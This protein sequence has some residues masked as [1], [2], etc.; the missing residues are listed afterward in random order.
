MD[1]PTFRS[2][3]NH[4]RLYVDCTNETRPGREHWYYAAPE[5][6]VLGYDAE[7]GQFLGSFGSDGFV[8][9]GQPPGARFQGELRYPTRAWDAWPPAY[10][11]FP[12]AVYEIH[13]SRR[14]IRTLFRP[15]SGETV[16]WAGQWRDRRDNKTLAVV[17]TDRSVHVLTEA[18]A[19]VVALPRAY[20][21]ARYTLNFVRLEGP[22]RY[23]IWY[24]PSPF[25]EPHEVATTPSHLV[26]YDAAGHE[27]ARRTVPRHARAEPSAAA[28][29]LGLATPPTELA[30]LAG[31]LYYLRAQA[32]ATGG[33][34]TWIHQMFLEES[35]GHFLQGIARG[36]G[37]PGGLHA[38]FVA[39]SLL[40]AVAGALVCFLLARRFAFSGA[41]SIAWALIGLLFGWAGVALMFALQDWPARIPCPACRRPRRVDRE[42]CEH[43]GAAHAVPAADGT[44]IFEETAEAPDPALAGH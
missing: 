44:E 3:R 25:L 36:T 34:D 23:V 7:L 40:A 9:A 1:W 18:G 29:L 14:T 35:T 8:P 2:Y 5:G 15:P 39:M 26:E 6:R 30:A 41:G 20:D 4:G 31:S 38:G 22:E 12:D 21:R 43:C 32:R 13:F 27:I 11:A 10:L 19:P 33:M 16:V 28:A 42:R 17:S 24:R 37:S